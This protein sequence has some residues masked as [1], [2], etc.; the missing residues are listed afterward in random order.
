M[1]TIARKHFGPYTFKNAGGVRGLVDKYGVDH[2]DRFN[3]T[4]LML[5]TRFGQE[6]GV[7]LLGEMQADASPVNTAGLTAFQ[8]MLQHSLRDRRYA[9]R[10]VP[11]IYRRLMPTSVTATVRGKLLKLHSHQAQFLF[12]NLLVALFHTR[13]A[14][15]TAEHRKLGLSAA[16]IEEVLAP[17]PESLVPAYRKRRSY[18]TGVLSSHEVD[19][20]QPYNKRVFKRTRRGIYILNPGMEVRVGDDWVSVYYGLLDPLTL[21][22]RDDGSLGSRYS[23]LENL[24]RMEYSTWAGALLAGEEVGAPPHEYR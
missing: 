19:R 16:D 8:I 4:P 23:S 21:L 17:L 12:Y 14:A 3:W 2:R 22:H 13:I 5:A 1:K 20:D 18:I 24:R 15:N 10:T 9:E 6:A 11:H 7:A